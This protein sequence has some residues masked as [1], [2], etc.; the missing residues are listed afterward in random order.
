[1]HVRHPPGGAGGVSRISWQPVQVSWTSEQPPATDADTV[2]I[3]VFEGQEPPPGAPQ[4]V[5]ELLG[6]GEARRS[7][8]SMA[9]THADGKRWL[10]V[11]L[12][13]PKDFTPERARMAAALARERAKELSTRALCWQVPHSVPA[14]DAPSSAHG[15]GHDATARGG[16]DGDERAVAAALVE[17]TVL[18]DYS[19]DTYKSEGPE[20][21]QGPKPDDE[22]VKHLERLIVSGAQDVQ[23]AVS[24]AAVVAEAANAARDLQNRPGND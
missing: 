10:I 8:K 23:S 6:S 7:P 21:A 20:Q 2:A 11:G 22:Q 13:V 9:V 19:F 1:V 15:A 18:A 4:A 5:Q 3:G 17:G 16:S 12:G 14:A 24:E